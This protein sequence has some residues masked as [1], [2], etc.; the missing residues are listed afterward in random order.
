MIVFIQACKAML[1]NLANSIILKALYNKNIQYLYFCV[2][3]IKPELLTAVSGLRVRS[4][5]SIFIV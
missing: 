4:V 5:L 3:E 1:Q 2:F